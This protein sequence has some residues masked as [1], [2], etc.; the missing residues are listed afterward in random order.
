[1]TTEILKE[2]KTSGKLHKRWKNKQNDESSLAFR[3]HRTRVSN[4]IKAAKRAFESDAEWRVDL[5]RFDDLE[6]C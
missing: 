2:L 1:M 5:S 3:Q 4:L 6:V